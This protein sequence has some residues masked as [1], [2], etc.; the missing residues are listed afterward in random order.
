MAALAQAAQLRT[1]APLS[2]LRGDLVVASYNLL[3]PCFVRPVDARTGT[4]QEFAAFK[5]C[6]DAV[7]E[8]PRRRDAL[9]QTLRQIPQ[10]CDVICLQEVEF[11]KEGDKRVPPAWLTDA[12]AGFEIIACKAS[13]LERNAKRNLRVVG[14]D[15]AVASAVAV[16][17]G[18]GWSVAWTGE[19]NGTTEVLVGVEKD[20]VGHVAVASV[21]LD[22][23]SEDKRVQ[24]LGATLAA[25]RARMGGGRNLRVIVAGDM[26]AEFK[27][28]SALGAVVSPEDGDAADAIRECTVALR[29]SPD[30]SELEAWAELRRIARFD[31]QKTLRSGLLGRVPTGATRC[32]Y[33]HEVAGSTAMRAWS[34]DHLLYS[35]ATLAPVA[36]WAT[37]EADAASLASGLPNASWPSDHLPVAAAFSVA[38]PSGPLSEA[39]TAGLRRLAQAEADANAAYAAADADDAAADAAEKPP[40]GGGKKQRQRCKPTPEAIERKRRRRQRRQDHHAALGAR[41]AEFVAALDEHDY[42]A[43]EARALL[44]RLEHHISCKAPDALETWAA[45]TLEPVEDLL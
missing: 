45:A 28:G 17:V 37:L 32:G 5:W 8:W 43:L 11:E 41:R 31:I 3:A 18:R 27:V 6:D 10:D 16:A 21:H 4:I 20:G 9:A 26:N 14:K 36:R 23:G 12:L 24:L 34:L 40:K 29:H 13:I 2:N 38:Y 22:A 30:A 1:A 15:V 35:P 19:H 7:L 25:A 33:D 44:L 42:D 39:A